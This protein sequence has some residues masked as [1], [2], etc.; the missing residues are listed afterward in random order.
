MST[1]E[2]QGYEKWKKKGCVSLRTCDILGTIG[3]F[4]FGWLLWVAYDRAGRTGWII[5]VPIIILYVL[6]MRVHFAFGIIGLAFYI[7][8]WYSIR[9]TIKGYQERYSRESEAPN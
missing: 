8:A 3:L 1:V 5:F 4:I 7:Y 9:K 2:E 6:G